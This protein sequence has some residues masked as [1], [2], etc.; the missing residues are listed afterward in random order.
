MNSSA[1]NPVVKKKILGI[2]VLEGLKPLNFYALFWCSMVMLIGITFGSVIQPVFL[3][4]VIKVS[5]QHFGKINANLVFLNEVAA[6]LFLGLSGAL[7]D[8]FGRKILM[9]LGFLISGII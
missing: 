4:E 9:I 6:I 3:K 5:P 8:K 7:S 1:Q 2:V